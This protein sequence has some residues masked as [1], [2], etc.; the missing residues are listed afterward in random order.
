MVLEWKPGDS[1]GE[2]I[3]KVLK[4]IQ[5]Y[6]AAIEEL[7]MKVDLFV[8]VRT[9]ASPNQPIQAWVRN[10]GVLVIRGGLEYGEPY[11]YF[12]MDHTLFCPSSFYGEDNSELYGLNQPLLEN[13]LRRWE[14]S[15]GSICEVEGLP[16]IYEY[17]FKPEEEWDVKPINSQ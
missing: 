5:E 12:D 15:L 9:Q 14:D 13:A 4:A 7:E 2:Y 3:E 10:L 17:G 16:G 11:L 1:Y 8:F 6:P